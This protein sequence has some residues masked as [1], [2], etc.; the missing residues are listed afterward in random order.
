MND[1]LNKEK[2]HIV[3]RSDNYVQNVIKVNI[4]IKNDFDHFRSKL[5]S[6]ISIKESEKNDLEKSYMEVIQNYASRE[7]QLLRQ[8]DVKLH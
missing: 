4:Q 6:E 8:V 2:A 5:N 1:L 7:K 3:E